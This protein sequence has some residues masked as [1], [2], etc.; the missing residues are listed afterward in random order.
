M[1]LII[2]GKNIVG[3]NIG[4]RAKMVSDLM[5][6]GD[7]EWDIELVKSLFFTPGC[8]GDPKY[9]LSNLVTKDRLVWVEDKKGRFTVRSAYKLAREIMAEDNNASCSDPMKLQSVWRGVWSMNLPNKIKHFAW[10][11]CSDILATK[12]SLFRRKI[13]VNNLCEACGKRVETIMHMLCFCSRGTEV[14]NASKLSLPFIIRES[15]SFV[16][17]F[18][19]LQNCWEAHLG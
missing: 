19:R 16:D 14:W 8:G 11:A 18:S 17:T 1:L 6:E 4:I 9:L 7:Q 13:R 15:W 2:C 10:K 5:K 12:D 3:E